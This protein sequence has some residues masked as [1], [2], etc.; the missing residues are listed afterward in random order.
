[1]EEV[2]S[3][4]LL[5]CAPALVFLEGAFGSAPDVEALHAALL[6]RGAGTPPGVARVLHLL[7]R[8]AAEDADGS[9]STTSSSGTFTDPDQQQQHE[10]EQTAPPIS[11][12]LAAAANVFDLDAKVWAQRAAGGK[13]PSTAPPASAPPPEQLLR[14]LQASS[15]SE[16]YLD[17]ASSQL[18]HEMPVGFI[19][20]WPELAALRHSCAPN[21]AVAVV[22]GGHAFVHAA[23]DLE[24]GEALTGNKIGAAILGPLALRQAAVKELTGRPC[25]CMRCVREGALPEEL[26][27]QLEELHA[28]VEG[29]WAAALEA[30]A[31][32]GDEEALVGLHVGLFGTRRAAMLLLG[33]GGSNT[34]R[35]C[36]RHASSTH[37]A[38]T[39]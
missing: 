27:Q 1:M 4:Q 28:R 2:V 6:A 13:V 11:A 35:A 20:V 15:Y 18:R 36:S 30:A 34:R 24:T 29:D 33:E 16:E 10:A 39:I 37:H 31:V 25:G 21:T 32:D 12:P 22:G 14:A 19:G 23:R 9:S 8:A 38:T 7:P 17:P 26:R 5:S 3:S